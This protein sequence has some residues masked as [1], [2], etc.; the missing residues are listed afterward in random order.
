MKSALTHK[1]PVGLCAH[2]RSVE[3]IA[4]KL[5]VFVSIINIDHYLV[6]IRADF[7]RLNV[8]AQLLCVC[9]R[10]ISDFNFYELVELIGDCLINDYAPWEATHGHDSQDLQIVEELDYLTVLEEGVDKF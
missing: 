9:K 7:G 3:C 1:I 8:K 6:I 10:K 4:P 2:L 5:L